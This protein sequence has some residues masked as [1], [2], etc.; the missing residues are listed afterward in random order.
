MVEQDLSRKLLAPRFRELGFERATLELLEHDRAHVTAAYRCQARSDVLILTLD[1]PGD[2]VAVTVTLGR[3]LQLERLF[4]QTALASISTFPV[5]VAEH[6][7]IE[8]SEIGACA[9]GRAPPELLDLL[10]R[11]VGVEGDGFRVRGLVAHPDPL[12]ARLRGYPLAD[13]ATAALDVMAEAVVAFARIWVERTRL[14]HLTVAGAVFEDPYL[15]GRLADAP[16]LESL[17]VCPAPGD[18]GLAIGAALGAA[19]AITRALEGRAFGPTY[20]EAH[21]YKALSVA[22]LPRD[23]QDDPASAAADLLAAGRSVAR[24]DGGLEIGRAR[25]NRAV[26][27]RPDD[28]GLRTRTLAGL[29]RPAWV[30]PSL[31]TSGA[32]ADDR[33]TRLAPELASFGASRPDNRATTWRAEGDAGRILSAFTQRTGVPALAHLELRLGGEPVVCTPTDAVRAWRTSEVDA[34]LL[35]PY[36]V[37]R[38]AIS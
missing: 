16:F 1:T 35:G 15:T 23:K 10:R 11:E 26:Y 12:A 14:P 27:V 13:I 3:H 38:S 17:T 29:R 33:A 20:T 6:L 36:L 24:F 32:A 28:A 7:G 2:G 8:A 22:S 31:V 19:G 30:A 4:Q 5:R 18:D 21:C 9:T 37:E 34:L 25:A